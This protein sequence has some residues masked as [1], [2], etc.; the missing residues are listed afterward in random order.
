MAA[1]TTVGGFA[2]TRAL[3]CGALIALLL[4]GCETQPMAAPPQETPPA[5][6]V[7]M[8]PA[9]DMPADDMPPAT[10]GCDP[11]PAQALLGE[12]AEADVSE[13]ARAAAGA[14]TVRTLAPGQATTREYAEGRLNL[15]LDADRRIV[16]AYC[17]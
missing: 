14:R 6:T 11:A 16:R 7:A 4:S 13:R 12:I 15:Q 8:P 9:H 2:V 10:V 3:A 1:G 5:P 17:G